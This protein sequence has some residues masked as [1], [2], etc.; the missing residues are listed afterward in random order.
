M[1]P[2]YKPLL[3]NTFLNGTKDDDGLIRAS[4]LSNLGEICRILGYKLG[5]IATEVKQAIILIV[6]EKFSCSC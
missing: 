5:T 6:I 1:A 2:K 4:S 3:L